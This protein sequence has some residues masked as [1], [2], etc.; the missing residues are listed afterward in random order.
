M[1]LS[2]HYYINILITIDCIFYCSESGAKANTGGSY[3]GTEEPDATQC[4]SSQKYVEATCTNQSCRNHSFQLKVGSYL[5]IVPV[6][7]TPS[8]FTS[9]ESNYLA[10]SV[11]SKSRRMAKDLLS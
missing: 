8:C 6:E 9:T 1:S 10:G 7:I 2:I 3:W 11:Y 5:P 4:Q